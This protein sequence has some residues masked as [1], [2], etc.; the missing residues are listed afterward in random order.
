MYWYINYSKVEGWGSSLQN[1]TAAL[2]LLSLYITLIT[3]KWHQSK[4]RWELKKLQL[5]THT[6][7]NFNGLKMKQKTNWGNWQLVR[8]TKRLEAGRQRECATCLWAVF[9]GGVSGVI[10]RHWQGKFGSCLLVL[11]SCHL[12]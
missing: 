2:R 9:V 5:T 10:L 7:Q 11:E 1:N 8:E 3:S 6:I 4:N 12:T